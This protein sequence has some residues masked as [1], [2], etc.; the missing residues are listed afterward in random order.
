MVS[1]KRFSFLFLVLL[2]CI[3][4]FILGFR[5]NAHAQSPDGKWSNFI[6]ISNTPTS[7][8]YPCI[9]ADKAGNVHV[10]WSEDVDGKVRNLLNNPDGTPA[11]DING[12]RINYLT[13]SGNTLY[14]SRWDGKKWSDPVD[15]QIS[16]TGILEYPAAAIDGDGTL[17]VIWVQTVSERASLYYSHV[18]V[19]EAEMAR[20]WENPI[21]LAGQ[22]LLANYPADIKIDSTGKIHIIFSQLGET[23]GLYSINSTDGGKSWSTPLRMY[24]TYDPNGSAE[25]VSPVR[26]FVDEKNRLHATWTRFGISGNGNAI[27]YSQSQDL[28]ET[29]TAPV[30]IMSVKLGWY[31]TDWLSIGVVG[32]EI[33]LVW[34]GGEIAYLNERISHNG[35]QTWDSSNQI[36]PKLVGENGF[37]NLMLDSSNQMHMIV[38]LRGDGFT[39]SN[40]VWY[41]T[42]DGSNWSEPI[43]LG[44]MDPNLYNTAGQ[45]N[46]EE[47][48]N[49][50]KGSFTGNGIRYP[51]A[52]M[53]NGN[54]LV[55]VVVNEW[56]GDIWSSHT[57]LPVP[58]IH[59]QAYLLTSPV[60]TTAEP[61]STKVVQ[62]IPTKEIIQPAVQAPSIASTN[63]NIYIYLSVA[64]VLLLIIFV[65]VIVYIKKRI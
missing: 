65:M 54:T 64:P 35:G 49:D 53:V 1:S 17:H 8:T 47:L 22:V 18:P 39:L 45:L 56:D 2:T 51:Q 4:L 25:G 62:S 55:F 58:E 24:Q 52:V 3:L 29:W 30:E 5:Y 15:V 44:T 20:K 43:L 21:V 37:A 61:T 36:L 31:E 27:Y 48:T 13:Q 10:L 11:F 46:E 16:P 38:V 34:E 9:V 14:Y 26:L 28:G 59:P 42:W 63:Q 12:N 57:T 32:D 60:P 23:P 50:L 7:S 19:G 41:S 40:G 33:H 6:N